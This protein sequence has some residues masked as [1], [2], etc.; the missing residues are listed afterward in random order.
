MNLKPKVSIITPMYNDEKYIAQTI[1]SVLSQTYGNWELLII[2][3]HS[4]DQ[5]VSIVKN[6]EDPRIHL[7]LNEQNLGAAQARNVGLQHATGDYVAFLD[8]DDLWMPKKLERQLAFMEEKACHFSCT[9]YHRLRTD[10]SEQLVTAP[11]VIN[12][13]MMIRCDYIGCLT[14]MYDRSYIGLIQVD[15]RIKKRNDYAIWLDVSKK[16]DCYFLPEVLGIYRV[17][18]GSISRVSGFTLLKYHKTLFSLQMG[19]SWIH[20]WFCAFRNGFHVLIKKKKY[21]HEAEKP[22]AKP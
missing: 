17:R 11:E 9:A 16:A 14:A 13:K 8:G 5:S 6:Y 18:P 19:Y 20:S 1:D 22:V 15:P 7:F 4:N 3:D 10:G 2:D 12:R 21:T